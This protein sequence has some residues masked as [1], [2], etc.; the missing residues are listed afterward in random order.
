MNAKQMP[1]SR[2]FDF[3]NK[4]E[5]LQIPSDEALERKVEAMNIPSNSTT[6]QELQKCRHRILEVFEIVSRNAVALVEQCFISFYG[7]KRIESML[8]DAIFQ[9]KTDYFKH[10]AQH[11]F[12][13][14]SKEQF[15]LSSITTIEQSMHLLMIPPIWV[16]LKNYYK[17]V[18]LE[19]NKLKITDVKS[20]I[21][22]ASD[23]NILKESLKRPTVYTSPGSSTS[24]SNWETVCLETPICS[25]KSVEQMH[26]MFS[27]HSIAYILAKCRYGI[28]EAFYFLKHL[29]L[30]NEAFQIVELNLRFLFQQEL[31]E[32][33]NSKT[34]LSARFSPMDYETPSG[35]NSNNNV[36]LAT[37]LWSDFTVFLRD[38]LSPLEFWKKTSRN[39]SEEEYDRLIQCKYRELKYRRHVFKYVKQ[40]ELLY[41][42]TVET[43]KVRPFR[44]L[45]LSPLSSDMTTPMEVRL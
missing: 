4:L 31:Q 1:S 43:R 27:S 17:Q 18:M 30:E 33:V 3:G 40:V 10:L 44:K 8:W 41:S 24:L 11:P 45:S 2:R 9:S 16:L 5:K 35:L 26:S 14:V 22:I 21:Q 13:N 36:S 20:L 39:R 37:S 6:L 15:S 29:H 42:Q 19:E 23:W 7:E 34:P 38:V 12:A 32:D 28:C 25:A